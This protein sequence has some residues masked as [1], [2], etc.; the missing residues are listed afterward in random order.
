M[1]SAPLVAKDAP[2]IGGGELPIDAALAAVRAGVPG[3]R[4]AAQLAEGGDAVAT[5]AL[6][7]PEADLDFGWVEP[8]RV[9]GRVV[10]REAP[11]QPASFQGSEGP[12]E[13]LLAVGVQVVHYE[14]DGPGRGV[15]GGDLLHR[16]GEARSLAVAG[17]VGQMA[18]ALGLGDAEDVRRPMAHVLVVAAGDPARDHGDSRPGRV[19]ELD[20][21]LIQRHHGLPIIQRFRQDLE[22]VLHPCHVLL[23]QLRNAP[24]FFPATASARGGSAFCESSLGLPWRRSVCG[25]PPRLSAPTSIATDLAALARRPSPRWRPAAWRPAASPALAS[26][27]RPALPQA[28][29]SGSATRPAAPLAGRCQ[30]HSPRPPWSS[31]DR[32]AEGCGPAATPAPRLADG[33]APSTPSGL[34]PKAPDLGTDCPSPFVSSPMAVDQI[35]RASASSLIDLAGAEH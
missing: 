6:A 9:L 18:P 26:R 25:S 10:H 3:A 19:E 20:R 34:R 4:S 8:A 32:A 35:T 30:R 11:P 24:H 29:P 2:C 7:R 22:D 33:P 28:R 12:D 14:V 17:G 15:G 1:H 21:A 27:P 5:E 16:V 13:R 31:L 23:V